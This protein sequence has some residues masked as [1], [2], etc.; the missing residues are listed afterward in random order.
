MYHRTVHQVSVL[1]RPWYKSLTF[2]PSGLQSSLLT[3]SLGI[4]SNDLLSLS[5][6]CSDSTESPMD[7]LSLEEK[8]D[9]S[10]VQIRVRT[11]DPFIKG[12]MTF[13]NI[14][15][16]NSVSKHR[17]P[18]KLYIFDILMTR[19]TLWYAFHPLYLSISRN[20]TFY[21]KADCFAN[22]HSW[23]LN[24]QVKVSSIN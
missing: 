10:F 24:W 19:P 13:F 20:W 6:I 8:V 4:Y 11:I 17:T 23:I 18:G 14:F 1:Q 3:L 16:N 21:E 5:L 12:Q 7:S 9:I 22:R 2:Y 15:L